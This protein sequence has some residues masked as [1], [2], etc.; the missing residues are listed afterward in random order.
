MA[1][2]CPPVPNVPLKGVPAIFHSVLPWYSLSLCTCP[3]QYREGFLQY[4][5]HPL[6]AL[7]QPHPD[8]LP[9][10][11]LAGRLLAGPRHQADLGDSARAALSSLTLS[12]SWKLSAAQST[13]MARLPGLWVGGL[14]G[15]ADCRNSR[16]D[17]LSSCREISRV[18]ATWT[19][20]A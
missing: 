18:A 12:V 20:L 5:H 3:V 1:L 2:C 6:P 11:G 16:S 15:P 14:L 13:M 19:R 8:P 4:L 17:L 7:P 10:L 9:E